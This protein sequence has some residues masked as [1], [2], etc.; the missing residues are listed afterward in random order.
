MF[1]PFMIDRLWANRGRT[2]VDEDEDDDAD[3][4]A[5]VGCGIFTAVSR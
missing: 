5:D 4:D 1:T 2:E 3:D